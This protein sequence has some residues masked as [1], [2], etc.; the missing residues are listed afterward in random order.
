MPTARVEFYVAKTTLY[1]I[2]IGRKT[3]KNNVSPLPPTNIFCDEIFAIKYKSLRSQKKKKGFAW[4]KKR[5]ELAILDPIGFET[6]YPFT[7]WMGVCVPF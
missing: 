6:Y 3:S 2:A 7:L 1:S 4:L 5:F